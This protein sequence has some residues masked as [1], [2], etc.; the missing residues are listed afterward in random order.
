ME[1]VIE[2]VTFEM[3]FKNLSP[4]F[5]SDEAFFQSIRD[6]TGLSHKK[7][8][9]QVQTSRGG[10]GDVHV[11]G[12]VWPGFSPSSVP[13]QIPI[14]KQSFGDMISWNQEASAL[15]QFSQERNRQKKV[16]LLS[17]T[18]LP[19]PHGSPTLLLPGGDSWVPHSNRSH[20]RRGEVG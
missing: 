4:F 1:A 14:A 3:F 19:S 12:D 2:D 5:D 6:M 15:E 11:S 8:S 17:S 7:P 13:F 9:I 16:P 18:P 10:N 20:P